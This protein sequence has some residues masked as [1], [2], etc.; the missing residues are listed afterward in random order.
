MTEALFDLWEKQ[1]E[2]SGDRVVLASKDQVARDIVDI[3]VKGIYEADHEIWEE[4]GKILAKR[5]KISRDEAAQSLDLAESDIVT[6]YER[7]D[8]DD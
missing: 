3:K 8:A 4:L 2:P 7:E 5:Y 1:F 6:I